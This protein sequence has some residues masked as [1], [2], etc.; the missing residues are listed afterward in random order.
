MTTKQKSSSPSLLLCNKLET[1]TEVETETEAESESQTRTQIQTQKSGF[2]P[3]VKELLRETL[4]VHTCDKRSSLSTITSDFPHYIIEP[5]FAE[6]DPLWQPDNRE[7]DDERDQRLQMCLDDIVLDTTSKFNEDDDDEHDDN[8]NKNT[9]AENIIEATFISLSTHS[10]AITSLL[11]IL[12]HRSFK[13][14]PGSMAPV[15]VRV[16]RVKRGNL[17]EGVR[18]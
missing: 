4:H 2:D 10:G 6:D 18:S 1:Q 14:L 12:G 7:T 8:H 3:I 9:K 15:V 11:Q 16:E 13:L 5:G 17:V